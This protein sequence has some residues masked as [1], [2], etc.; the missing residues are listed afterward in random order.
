MIGL[1]KTVAP[2]VLAFI[3]ISAACAVAIARRCDAGIGW[4]RPP[5]ADPFFH[6]FGEMPNVPNPGVDATPPGAGGGVSPIPSD[7]AARCSRYRER[8]RAF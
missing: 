5:P 1:L 7:A 3:A 2:F 8:R 6:P 4:W